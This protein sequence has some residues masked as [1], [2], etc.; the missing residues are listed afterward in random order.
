MDIDKMILG[1]NVSQKKRVEVGNYVV[2]FRRRKV[3]RKNYEYIYVVELFFMG[4]LVRKG[5]FTEYSNAVSFAG[6]IMYS[7]L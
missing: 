4:N 7:L 3:S 6:E 1:Y 2:K 5:I